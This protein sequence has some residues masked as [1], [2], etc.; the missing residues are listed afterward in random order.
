MST[1][2]I[3]TVNGRWRIVVHTGTTEPLES[4]DKTW[5]VIQMEQALYIWWLDDAGDL[6]NVDLTP[7]SLAIIAKRR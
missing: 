7:G 1:V 3:N 4:G 6:L 5:Q 2:M